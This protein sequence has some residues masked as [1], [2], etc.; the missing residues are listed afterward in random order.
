MLFAYA[1]GFSFAYLSL[2]TA[3]GALLLF[4]RCRRR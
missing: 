4:G 2:T 1:A 3:T